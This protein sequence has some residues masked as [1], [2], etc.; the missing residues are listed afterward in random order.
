[1]RKVYVFKR[2]TGQVKRLA[3]LTL[4]T[5]MA[6]GNLF[7][8][9]DGTGT[10][11]KINSANELVTG[12]YVVANQAG[13]FAMNNVVTGTNTKVLMPAAAVFTNPA[14]NIVWLITVSSDGT[15]TLFNEESGQY[16]AYSGS[17]NSAYMITDLSDKGRWTPSLDA[18]G[19]WVL[20]N[21]ATEG[22]YLNYNTSSP[23]FACY[24]NHNQQELSLY[25]LNEGGDTPALVVFPPTFSL[26]TGTYYTEQTVSLTATEGAN[27]YY[28]LNDGDPILYNGPFTVNATATITAY[29]VSGETQSA[30]ATVTL[31]FPVQLNNI[32]AYYAAANAEL[33][34]INSDMTFVY[35]SGRYIFVKDATG[36]LLIYDYNTPVIT[37][38]YN[39][40][41]VFTGGL[42]G[43]RSMYHGLDEIVPSLNTAEGVAG[44]PVAPI[45]VTAAELLANPANYM[46]QLVMVRN[47]VFNG[48]ELNNINNPKLFTQDGN[49]LVVYNRFNH[50]NN[51]DVA[52]GLA[53]TLVGFVSIYNDFVQIFPRNGADIISS[54]ITMPYVC[55]FE[56]STGETWTLVNG[57]NTNKWFI[58]QAQGFNNNKLYISSSNGV[59]NKYNVTAASVTH[60]CAP[61]TLPAG[62]VLLTFDV[63]TVGNAND[64]LQ[65][66]IMDEAP[67]AGTLPTDYLTRIYG[68]NEFT[69]QTVVIPASY[70]GAKYLVF[71]WNNNNADGNQQPA[72]IDNI[73]LKNTCEMVTDITATVDGHT[74]VLT[75]TAPAGQNSW[76]VECKEAAAD[77]WQSVNV[78]EATL[79]LNNLATDRAYDVR[80][81]SNCGDAASNWATSQFFVPCITTD[82][83]DMEF[84]VGDGTSASNV[85]PLNSNYRNSWTQMVYPASSFETPGFINSISW[86]VNAVNNHSYS[87]LQIYLGT[88]ASDI[89]ESTSDWLSMDDL[90]LV[91]DAEN[92]TAGTAEGWETYTL[93]TPYYYNAQDNLVIV[94]ARKA[95]AYNSIQ[96]RYT[97]V[98]N[99]VLYRRSDSNS[100]YGDH[101]GTNTGTRAANLPNMFLDYTGIV[102]VD[103][104]CKAPKKPIVEHHVANT[105]ISWGA[106][107]GVNTY[108]VQCAVS[109]TNNWL[110]V[111]VEDV[112][113]YTINGLEQ[114][115]SYDVRVR[116]IC[117]AEENLVSDWTDIVTFTR[118][119][120]CNVPTN[121]TTQLIQ[122]YSTTLTWDAG[123]GT[124]WTVEYGEN[125]F[126]QGE[127]TVV[128]T[129]TNTVVLTGLTPETTYQVYVKANCGGYLSAWSSAYTFTSG[130]AP[131]TVTE[132]NPWNEDFEEY[133]GSG[134]K[135]LSVCWNTPLKVG[136][137]PFVYCSWAPASH[138]G[139]NSLELKANAN[140]TV[141]VALPAFTNPLQDL[142]MTYYARLYDQTPGTVE[143]G[144]ITDLNDASTFVAVQTVE[145]QQGSYGR[146]NA[147]LYGPFSFPG[148][149]LTGARI[150]IRFT[151]AAYNTSWNMDDFSVFIPQTCPVPTD[152]VFSDITSEGASVDWTVN[153]EETAWTVQY[154]VAGFVLGTGTI[155]NVTSRPFAITGLNEDTEYDVYVKAVCSSTEESIWNGPTTFNTLSN[156]TDQCAYTLVLDDSYG[157]GWNGGVVT[158]SQNGEMVGSYTIDDGYNATYTVMLCK[159]IEAIVT[160][161][162]GSYP[163]ENSFQLKDENNFVVISHTGAAGNLAQNITPN[164]G[165]APVVCTSTCAYTLVLNDSYGD[166]WN[167]G[168]VTASQ[169]GVFSESY[170]IATGYS[171]TYTLDLCEGEE[172][173]ISYVP[174]SYPTENSLELRDPDGNVIWSHSGGDGANA[175]TVTPNCGGDEPGGCERT[176]DYT[177]VLTDSYGD[178]W[179]GSSYG[180]VIGNVEVIQNEETVA[181]LTLDEGASATSMV[182]LCDATATTILV[183]PDYWASEMGMIVYDPEGN[184]VW[185]FDGS[186]LD[187]YGYAPDQTF[188]FTTNCGDVVECAIP[189]EL[190]LQA[191]TETSATLAWEGDTAV[192]YEVNCKASM[193]AEWTT[194]T[195][196]G[197]QVTLTGLTANTTYFV[198]VK[199]LCDLSNTYTNV[200]TFFTTEAEMLCNPYEYGQ[201]TS[202]SQ[203]D[204]P[205][206]TYYRNSYTQQIFTPEEVGASGNITSL[207]FNYAYSSTLTS[208]TNVKIY[209]TT[210]N[211]ETFE[212]TS[213]WILNGLVQVYSGTFNCTQG[214]N[215]FTFD[216]PFNYDGISNLVV[217]VEDNSGQYNSSS[218]KFYTSTENSTNKTLVYYNDSY[219]FTPTGSYRY[220]RN[221]R[222]NIRFNVCTSASDIALRAI[223]NIPNAC[224]LS[225]V[226]VKLDIRNNGSENVSTIEAYYFVNE[227][228]VV[229]ETITLSEPLA[230]GQE[231]TYTFNTLANMTEASNV[232][233]A[234]VEV[235]NDGNFNNNILT[236]NPIMLI[237]AVDVPFVETFTPGQI[238]DGWNMIDANGDNITF[239]I[240]NGMASYTFNDEMAADDWLMTTCMY[241]P[242]GYWTPTSYVVSYTYNA[243]DPTMVENFGVYYGKKVNGE[244]VMDHEVATHEF[245]N[246]NMVTVKKLITVPQSG[247]YYFGIHATSAAGN[248]GFNISDFSVKPVVTYSVYAAEHGLTDPEGSVKSAMGEEVTVTIVPEE[249]YHV[250]AIYKNQ[251]LVRGEND[252]NASVEFYTFVP[253]NWDNIYVT[254]ASNKY[255]VDATVESLSTIVDYAGAIY[256]PAHEVVDH[257]GTHNGLITVAPYYHIESVTVNNNDVLSSLEYLGDRQFELTLSPVK[258]NKKIN[259]KTAIDNAHIVYV[260][261]AGQG[262]INGE[263]E[264]G[265]DATYPVVHTL[266]VPGFSD[267]LSTFVPAPGYHVS[268][269]IIDSVEHNIIEAFAFE[270]LVGDHTIEITFEKDHYVIST[271]SIGNGDVS[272]S[273][274]FD[275]DPDFTYTFTATPD[276]GYLIASITRNGIPVNVTDP[277][278]FTE[279]LTNIVSD[280][281]YEA[282]FVEQVFSVTALAGANG[283]VSPDG[284]S[285]YFYHQDAEIV[286]TADPGYYISSLTY[287]GSTYTF[288][289]TLGLTT[290]TIPFLNIEANHT[291]SATF[292]Q[293]LYNV[294]V[295]AGA[296][297]EI[298]P[299]TGSFAYGT[300]PTFTITP[301]AGYSIVDV[302]VDGESVGAV[303]TYTF[304][305]LDADHTIAATFS[306]N[307][308]TINATAGTG[309]SIA[310]AGNTT[311]AY[312][313]TQNYTISA[314]AGY[315]LSD[316]FVDGVSVGAVTSYSFTNVTANHTIYAVFETNDYTVTVNAPNHG[317]ITP[318]SM[319]VAYGATPSFI[320]TPDY[321]YNVTA[322][323]V[324][325]TNVI[326]SATNVNGV[327]TYTFPAITANQTITATMAAKTYTINATAGSNGSIS[328]S[329]NTTVNHG[330]TQVYNITPSNGYV[331]D[332][333]LVDGMSMGAVSSYVFTNVVANHTI[334][335]TFKMV[336][337][338]A[339]SFLYTTHIDSNSAMLHWSHPT[340]TSFDIQYKTLTGSLTSI[341]AVSGNSYQLTDLT[342]NTTYL[343]QVRAN[344]T[345]SNHSDWSGMI[346]FTTDNVTIINGIDDL[347]KNNIKVYAERQ[348]VHILN[349]EGMNIEQVRIFDV[350]GKLIYTGTVNSNHEVIGLTVATGTY[351]VNVATDNG[352]ANYKVTLM[353]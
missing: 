136:S 9:Y 94:V 101:P 336:E 50:L 13:E 237:E 304:T 311:V 66:S 337:C 328:P 150:A 191:V 154:G 46:S 266:I 18:E 253:E 309:G 274:E 288:D 204:V 116:S 53:A 339:P 203:Y 298:T 173:V 343:W 172:A 308:Y 16:A 1:M 251:V 325:G 303:T 285:N 60:A 114:G 197:T 4:I 89:N 353:K 77:I 280:Y 133:T 72:A 167:G 109:G 210:T 134:E 299:G 21:V 194:L 243:N 286:V 261:N 232:V 32:A 326:S 117:D 27:I 31:T 338:E 160:Y 307:Q 316:V 52:E 199:A 42:V 67:E 314:S 148:V 138:S 19:N 151:S 81:R 161:T 35:R 230:Q 218:Y 208:K 223:Q 239:T 165:E 221:Y 92:G 287:D 242:S 82:Y 36:G 312:N 131:I 137:S 293:F 124:S 107:P 118:P 69:T 120:Y 332:N 282:T 38:Q 320:I 177:F 147:M 26:P 110:S 319:T 240:G 56:G 78:N 202:S 324:N 205:V 88:K 70:A 222:T 55:D 255:H 301:D 11:T 259:V 345:S 252:D 57:E 189:T 144:Y 6:V 49:D 201:G 141:M 272:E 125:G 216:E 71:S 10:F 186:D 58:G 54:N 158:I 321:G 143:V 59:T 275:Y 175:I 128:T 80:V 163:G 103:A 227:G 170:T 348:N 28:S 300:T 179:S 262:T 140:Q 90:T 75:W 162:Q 302:T 225:N 14:A 212:S 139:V 45:E 306:A 122:A 331:I 284:V 238:N 195:V 97:S 273:V 233:T 47:G 330:A 291:I 187:D 106:A 64:Y 297:G 43:T 20:E 12:Y 295:N 44:S 121:I 264:V 40:G 327:Y 8:E 334:S 322:I 155:E 145:P 313:G 268:S 99:S 245:S 153:G 182:N 219:T 188:E 111:I 135:P 317:T 17:G 183:H 85:A 296:H 248:A 351:I 96:Y 86:Y 249:G 108:E 95:S 214:W 98:T 269:V 156:C 290:T 79:T 149:N 207:A 166:G 281:Y 181:T 62:D 247:I 33:V 5:L 349:N 335:A 48:G 132:A 34:K 171:E 211:K 340:A 115:N 142:Q 352:V 196:T 190:V 333:V 83:G 23:R 29:A 198:K 323:T 226:P 254:F 102:C 113:T 22:R 344:C 305:A 224:D 129:N 350:Y 241:V 24:G 292:A 213:D 265:A 105:T 180:S 185:N 7:A 126:T 342:P 73:V 276:A 220:V 193:D 37:T 100:E 235:P 229:H 244:F 257:G 91:Y 3:A 234:W 63:R 192:T 61:I 30:N 164:C 65:V 168:V 217:V 127:G 104:P 267:V 176:C 146:A 347:V 263:F 341:T 112:T 123:D 2:L 271:L 279:T 84:T 228:S 159:G 76:T 130:C 258:E 184:V 246:T 74:A 39:E 215:T 260:V 270:H 51:A 315:H 318:N 174:G 256:T 87:S 250:S 152:V 283:T 277:S 289:Q 231:Y 206:N 93:S 25:K 346:S 236:S 41:D 169:A 278:Q 209:L 294:T 200:L 310:P 178:G 329:G 68:V 157:D 15:I 119:I